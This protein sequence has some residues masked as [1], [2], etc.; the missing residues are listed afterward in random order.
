MYRLQIVVVALVIL[1][2]NSSARAEYDTCEEA[3]IELLGYIV[4]N[5]AKFD[6]PSKVKCAVASL[7]KTAEI[8]ATQAPIAP[9][10]VSSDCE[11]IKNDEQASCAAASLQNKGMVEKICFTSSKGPKCAA[12]SM[13]SLGTIE[14][15]CDRVKSRKADI[16]LAA[17]YRNYK[18]WK[19]SPKVRNYFGVRDS[20]LI[21]TDDS[22]EKKSR[23]PSSGL[24]VAPIGTSANPIHLGAGDRN[25]L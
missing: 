1:I 4:S 18:K 3:S 24:S 22:E 15:Y 21:L 19:D 2:N 16:C 7:K 10:S 12:A 20:C 6:T 8:L 23:K 14:V 5:C 9:P 25:G 13:L 17:F 11:K